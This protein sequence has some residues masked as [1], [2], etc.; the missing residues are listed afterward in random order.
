M[1]LRQ[2]DAL[3]A[4]A[5][6][7]RFS[8][9]AR[10]LHTVQS[11][12]STHVARLEDEL[13]AILVDRSAGQLTPEG[14]V[15]LARA[16]RVNAELEAMRADVSSMTSHVTG[17]VRMG[18]I[19]TTGRWLLPVLLDELGQAHPDVEALVIDSTT[20][21]LLPLLEHG[22][23]DLAI[24]NLPLQHDEM[25]TSPLFSE[26][27]VV[28]APTDHPLAEDGD[29]PVEIAELEEHRFLLGPPGSNLRDQI[30]D[31]ATQH[32]VHLRTLAELDGIRLTATLAFQGYGPAIVP[33]TAIPAWAARGE[34]NVL[35]LPKM[36]RRNVGLAIR[37]RG[38]LSAP[39][40]A[41]R[42]ILRRVVRD[43]APTIDGLDAI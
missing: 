23:L 13:G 19:G 2:L 6:H 39:A 10:A 26:E 20:T 35:S 14:E 7:G 11:N 40:A 1:D 16:R 27:L 12:I 38:M 18:V 4:V 41:A 22:E 29:R 31:A 34:W 28:I 3:A 42:D 24:I 43:L 32:G 8:A 17:P 9:A 30:D 15:V 37:R 5:E 21:A 36:P 33:L 25:V